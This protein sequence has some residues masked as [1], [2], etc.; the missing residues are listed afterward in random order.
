MNVRTTRTVVQFLCLIAISFLLNL[1][2]NK[3]DEYAFLDAVL[4]K[5]KTS[6][7]EQEVT[8]EDQS[9]ETEGALV[10]IADTVEDV[11]IELEG[12]TTVFSPIHDAYLQNGKGYN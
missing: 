1:S 11:P 6:V 5:E 2:C 7:N 12:R 9:E 3:E 8:M 4:N 10:E